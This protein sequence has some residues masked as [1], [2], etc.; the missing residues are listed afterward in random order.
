MLECRVEKADEARGKV[1]GADGKQ[2]KG[3]DEEAT[4]DGLVHG[5]SASAS[6]SLRAGDGK[7]HHPS[8]PTV[9]PV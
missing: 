4:V 7:H 2:T 8:P 1:T 5:A 6:G 3:R 9:M